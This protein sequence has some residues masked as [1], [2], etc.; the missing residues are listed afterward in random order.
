MTGR[1]GLG[2]VR[3]PAR[4]RW[5][6]AVLSVLAV[7]LVCDELAENSRVAAVPVLTSSFK[8]VP[9]S[10]TAK[11][12][13]D[14]VAGE[15]GKHSADAQRR[16]ATRPKG[17]APN[18]VTDNFSAHL[19]LGASAD[20]DDQGAGRYEEDGGYGHSDS[21]DYGYG[22][23]NERIGH[24]NEFDHA[25]L[26]DPEHGLAEEWENFMRFDN[27]SDAA[28]DLA[29]WLHRLLPPSIH[30][31][32]PLQKIH[33]TREFE[34]AD[35]GKDGQL[36]WEDWKAMM[37]HE[38]PQ[39]PAWIDGSLSLSLI[40]VR[41]YVR[42]HVR[43]YIHTNT[44]VYIQTYYMHTYVC[45][46]YIQHTPQTTHI[47]TYT[48]THTHSH[49]HTHTH[50][51]THAHTGHDADGVPRLTED[52]LLS[53][54]DFGDKDNNGQLSVEELASV[55]L[56]APGQNFLCVC[57]CMSVC[58]CVCVSV[59]LCVCVCVCLCVCVSVY[60]CRCRH[61]QL[62]SFSK[63]ARCVRVCVRVCV[64]VCVCVCMCVES[65]HIGFEL[66]ASAVCLCVCV[67]VCV[68]A[69]VRARTCVCVYVWVC[70]CA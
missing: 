22:G 2:G 68:R 63:P 21:D 12:R 26:L 56:H 38:L 6:N 18:P 47:H 13:E 29:E 66:Q 32:D 43:T 57:V 5:Q 49:S 52:R 8:G 1:G 42:M 20:G 17:S 60:V 55:L 34:D 35:K 11:E 30:E 25:R 14:V 19:D 39:A 46:L 45:T 70:V 28:V 41:T 37:F 59:C 67:C 31:P 50:T 36:S 44:Y 9:D 69:C 51:H 15:V 48:H 64:C 4:Q 53:A 24:F 7:V 65:Q 23:E 54:F 33:W 16:A 3:S 62:S 61:M 10:A 58:L 40:Y 27:N